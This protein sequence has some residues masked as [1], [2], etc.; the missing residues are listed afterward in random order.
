MRET[1]TLAIRT[2]SRKEGEARVGRASL[3]GYVRRYYRARRHGACPS[4]PCGGPY[5]SNSGHSKKLRCAGLPL[6]YWA[7]CT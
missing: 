3:R 6:W 4:A 1:S 2:G 5:S 7:R